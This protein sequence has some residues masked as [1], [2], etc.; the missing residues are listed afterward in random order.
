MSS[1]LPFSISEAY[2]DRYPGL[3]F[4]MTLISGC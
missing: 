2:R 3:A 4:G 1:P